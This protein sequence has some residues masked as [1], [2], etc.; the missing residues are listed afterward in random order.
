MAT[1]S[2]CAQCQFSSKCGFSAYSYSPLQNT[3][4]SVPK[5]V[6]H[7]Y[8][9]TTT[10]CNCPP[11]IDSILINAS[12]S[13]SP[14]L[15]LFFSLSFSLSLHCLIS[16]NIECHLYL[17]LKRQES[18]LIISGP[19]YPYVRQA[20]KKASNSLIKKFPRRAQG[21]VVYAWTGLINAWPLAPKTPTQTPRLGRHG[22]Q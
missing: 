10:S 4:R 1:G 15:S 19:H 5:Y 9:S 7:L 11:R 8:G 3:R 20:K 13:P 2:E 18:Q 16:Y 22:E 14:S 21:R 12:F 6:L 17:N